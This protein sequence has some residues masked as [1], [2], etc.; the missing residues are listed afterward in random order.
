[1]KRKKILI[2][3][4]GTIIVFSL[5]FSLFLILKSHN[6]VEAQGNW[7]EEFIKCAKDQLGKPYVWGTSGPSS[8]DC[9]GLIQYCYKQATGKELPLGPGHGGASQIASASKWVSSATTNFAG[10]QPG[11]VVVRSPGYVNPNDGKRRQWGHIGI[12]IGDFNGKKNV[13]IHAGGGCPSGGSCVNSNSNLSQRW[14]QAYRL[15]EP[16]GG[17]TEISYP[18]LSPQEFKYNLTPI[19]EINLDTL[20]EEFF[21]PTIP[22]EFYDWLSYLLSLLLMLG[23]A[24]TT[25]AIVIS[26]IQYILTA[27]NINLKSSAKNRL[28]NAIIGLIL[29]FSF[30]IILNT[31]DPQL[32]NFEPRKPSPSSP[33]PASVQTAKADKID[34]FA[35]AGG[36]QSKNPVSNNSS[37]IKQATIEYRQDLTNIAAEIPVLIADVN[38]DSKN[39]IAVFGQASNATVSFFSEETR[40]LNDEKELSNPRIKPWGPFQLTR[41]ISDSPIIIDID[42]DGINEILAVTKNNSLVSW[43]IE[44][45]K[46]KDIVNSINGVFIDWEFCLSTGALINPNENGETCPPSN[47][48]AIGPF[49][50]DI[51]NNGIPETIIV[52]TKQDSPTGPQQSEE[53]NKT[54]G[55]SVYALVHQDFS[56]ESEEETKPA[57][58]PII[59]WQSFDGFINETGREKMNIDQGWF[60]SGNMDSDFQKEIIFV[61]KGISTECIWPPSAIPNETNDCYYGQEFI[62]G[63]CSLTLKCQSENP[64]ENPTQISVFDGLTGTPMKIKGLSNGLPTSTPISLKFTNK[65]QDNIAIAWQDKEDGLP[66]IIIFQPMTENRRKELGIDK[67]TLISSW[68]YK[69][70]EIKTEGEIT[71]GLVERDKNG[72]LEKIIGMA[73]ADLDND[74][75]NELIIT[76]SL[77]KVFAL[78]WNKSG[79]IEETENFIPITNEIS[80]K[81]EGNIELLWKWQEICGQDENKNPIPCKT[82]ISPPTLANLYDD[83]QKEIIIG[84]KSGKIYLLDNQGVESSKP[85]STNLPSGCSCKEW[86]TSNICSEKGC[87]AGHILYKRTCNPA[88]CATQEEC[89]INNQCNKAIWELDL[90]KDL[91]LPWSHPIVDTDSDGRA[92]II[93]AGKNREGNNGQL[94]VLGKLDSVKLELNDLSL[95]NLILFEDHIKSVVIDKPINDMIAMSETCGCRDHCKPARSVSGDAK[96]CCPELPCFKFRN[97]WCVNPGYP[98]K[99][100]MPDKNPNYCPFT[101]SQNKTCNVETNGQ[102]INSSVAPINSEL[103]KLLGQ[104]NVESKTEEGYYYKGRNRI[105]IEG[106]KTGDGLSQQEN[107]QY[108]QLIKLVEDI[109][110]KLLDMCGN[111]NNPNASCTKA[112]DPQTCRD[113][114][115][116]KKHFD[117]TRGTN[118]YCENPETQRFV[119]KF[120]SAVES[121]IIKRN[122]FFE[123]DN[124]NLYITNLNKVRDDLFKMNLKAASCKKDTNRL[125]GG[126]QTNYLRHCYNVVQ[127]DT[128]KWETQLNFA[129]KLKMESNIYPISPL[130]LN[131]PFFCSVPTIDDSGKIILNPEQQQGKEINEAPHYCAWDDFYCMGEADKAATSPDSLLYSIPQCYSILKIEQEVLSKINIECVREITH[132]AWGRHHSKI[133][134][135]KITPQIE[136]RE[137]HFSFLEEALQTIKRTYQL[138][139]ELYNKLLK[140]SCSDECDQWCL[141]KFVCTTDS[142]PIPIRVGPDLCCGTNLGSKDIEYLSLDAI[143]N[144]YPQRVKWPCNKEGT[145]GLP[146][147][148]ILAEGRWVK[149]LLGGLYDAWKET[150]C[151]IQDEYCDQCKHYYIN[152]EP[153][154]MTSDELIKEKSC[155]I[156]QRA[157]LEGITYCEAPCCRGAVEKLPDKTL[158]SSSSPQ[159]CRKIVNL[160]KYFQSPPSALSS[161]VA[162]VKNYITNYTTNILPSKLDFDKLLRQTIN[163]KNQLDKFTKELNDVKSLTPEEFYNQQKQKL[164]NMTDEEKEKYVQKEI[165]K[166]EI[167]KLD[168]EETLK[169]IELK[170]ES[171]KNADPEKLKQDEIEKLQNINPTEFK[172]QKIEEISDFV[173]LYQEKTNQSIIEIDTYTNTQIPEKT[174]TINKELEKIKQKI[175]EIER[176]SGELTGACRQISSDIQNLQSAIE[177]LKNKINV[178]DLNAIKSQIN[179]L[180]EKITDLEENIDTCL[181]SKTPSDLKT[182][183][184][185]LKKSLDSF[186]SLITT[187]QEKLEDLSNIQTKLENWIREKTRIEKLDE[188]K[189]LKEEIERLSKMTPEKFIEEL[190][191]KLKL[192]KELA[193]LKWILAELEKI[194]IENSSPEDFIASLII[195]LERKSAKPSEAQQEKINELEEI[196]QSLQKK[197]DKINKIADIIEKFSKKGEEKTGELKG[198]LEEEIGK[199][200]DKVGLDP[201]LLEKINKTENEITEITNKIEDL[202]EDVK[203]IKSKSVSGKLEIEINKKIE[204]LQEKLDFLPSSDVINDL[205]DNLN[206]ITGELGQISIIGVIENIKILKDIQKMTDEIIT[207]LETIENVG[208]IAVDEIITKLDEV[209]EILNKIKNALEKVQELQLINLGEIYKIL[210]NLS[211]PF[212]QDLEETGGLKEL[213]ILLETAESFKE[214]T[215]NEL[216]EE[217]EKIIRWQPTGGIIIEEFPEQSRYNN[218]QVCFAYERNSALTL[219]LPSVDFDI[220]SFKIPTTCGSIGLPEIGEVGPAELALIAAIDPETLEIDMDFISR[221]FYVLPNKDVLKIIN[222]YGLLDCIKIEEGNGKTPVWSGSFC[223]FDEDI[224][225][226][227]IIDEMPRGQKTTQQCDIM[228]IYFSENNVQKLQEYFIAKENYGGILWQKMIERNSF[229]KTIQDIIDEVQTRDAQNYLQYWQYVEAVNQ[230]KKMIDNLGEENLILLLTT[231]EL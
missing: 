138:T 105:K 33:T 56:K 102:S 7:R 201:K 210:E 15:A 22:Q 39:E 114:C 41:E 61:N 11:D 106:V 182:N 146:Y 158:I 230:T 189:A 49:I 112:T 57:P 74:T 80:D 103:K 131:D 121:E 198:K 100:N 86:K 172:K 91:S 60:V 53:M 25:L 3:I 183:L 159:F 228:D 34:N 196:I 142:F 149:E 133:N 65:I 126:I 117:T 135:F 176:R 1:M 152:Y 78:D 190:S 44:Y 87:P 164:E 213:K 81:I 29:L 134:Y 113:A 219:S 148:L 66:T 27:E 211:I 108:Q 169:D 199:L 226:S 209:L 175:E 58:K 52:A 154:E 166:L 97:N 89:V 216:K 10:I 6:Q 85:S 77:G 124:E 67:N 48:G 153:R 223:G 220:P 62:N 215:L 143:L 76:T 73:A 194:K 8:F 151:K 180:L 16:G 26:G 59:L 5:V 132:H 70:K 229:Y 128:K 174:K 51:D 116:I 202:K 193:K 224:Y 46:T 71:T 68:V 178:G 14:K 208:G 141:Y 13:V 205:N 184:T 160:V 168:A 54:I 130:N 147:P 69:L 162:C 50:T 79:K 227:K 137:I 122:Y 127:Q 173:E 2:F 12:Y 222:E 55:G 212:L 170:S 119:E 225:A 200:E 188:I 204:E 185:N 101:T 186:K 156:C 92:E 35:M 99:V 120:K 187:F 107:I 4:S 90:K 83:V 214:N 42:G 197:L 217:V 206:K 231:S 177:E 82:L 129:R 195:K 123:E 125:I 38:N 150:K 17:V 179:N 171:I 118:N 155:N 221:I 203:K 104:G 191:K 218:T 115:F 165:E 28:Q 163:P 139:S 40:G 111:P 98:A 43:K 36:N 30:Y 192:Q 109:F 47:I 31:A 72:N 45:K 24:I 144:L 96:P 20:P 37:N 88:N 9:S 19:P 84:S 161:N 75:N 32:L 18:I 167:Q 207:Q 95:T 110:K 157:E 136:K 140:A 145:D 21:H 64:Y 94:F 23:G 181:L 93:I 63:E